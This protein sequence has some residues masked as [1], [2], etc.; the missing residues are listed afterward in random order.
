MSSNKSELH[1]AALDYVAKGFKIIPILPGA[2]TPMLKNWREDK[3]CTPDQVDAFFASNPDCN[4]AFEPEDMGYAVIDADTYHEKCNIQSLDL[5]ETF[6]VTTPRGGTHYYFVGSAP[7]TVGDETKPEK[8]LGPH[9]DTRGR[10]SYALLPPSIVEGKRYEIRNNR[11][12]VALPVEIEA[13]LSPR[14]I[15]S[16]AIVELDLP[17]NITRARSHLSGLVRRGRIAKLGHRGHDTTYE[18]ACELVRDLGISPYTA[19]ELMLDLWYPFCEPNDDPNFVRERVMSAARNG[20][21]APGAYAVVPPEEAFAGANLPAPSQEAPI[22]GRWFLSAKEQAE[23]PEPSW[24]IKD[25]L[26]ER[27]ITILVAPKGQFKTFLALEMCMAVAT[28]KET[29]GTMP[30]S[31]GLVFYGDHESVQEI[32]KFHRPAWQIVHG[33][34]ANDETGFYLSKE[35]PHKAIEGEMDSFA[36]ECA[37]ISKRDGRPIKLI[38]FDTYSATMLGLDENDP[39]DANGFVRY[40]RSLIQQFGCSVLALTHTGKDRDRGARGTSALPAGVDTVLEVA[41]EEG[42]NLVNLRVVHHRH[43]PEKRGS[44]KFEGRPVANSLVFT[45]LSPEESSALSLKNNPYE[46]RKVAAALRKLGAVT[47]S[48]AVP[49]KVLALELLPQDG[50]ESNERHEARI[51]TGERTLRALARSVLKR[52]TFGERKYLRWTLPV[53]AFTDPD[54][55]VLG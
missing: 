46:E 2:K 10:G 25:V 24:L 31:S 50:D 38:V 29:F 27:K 22:I 18:V 55:D 37:A 34:N 44:F 26:P 35:G 21:N 17:A 1:Q 8:A 13:R 7:T 6:Q 30:T 48:T 53:G 15:Q 36:D 23:L 4:L 33:L 32:A 3:L 40:C 39:N 54:A 51:E 19:L 41:R 42:T 5:P 47:D 28:G 16:H 9:I 11:T 14:D 49:T 45:L 12:P 52:F 43:A 20:Q